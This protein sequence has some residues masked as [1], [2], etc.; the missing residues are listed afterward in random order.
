MFLLG[1]IMLE[2]GS[3]K[4]SAYCYDDQNLDILDKEIRDRLKLIREFYSERLLKYITM[5]VEY[6][7]S[8]RIFATDMS[9][10]FNREL[11]E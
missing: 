11:T 5:L 3:L 4:P 10:L 9:L 2:C 8:E 7:Y 1:M 6:D